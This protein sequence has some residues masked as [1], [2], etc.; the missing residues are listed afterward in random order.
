MADSDLHLSIDSPPQ[1]RVQVERRK[2]G[3]RAE[4]TVLSPI[5]GMS[6]E[7]PLDRFGALRLQ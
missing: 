2:A 1:V 5:L 7:Y 4:R 6:Y 3:A